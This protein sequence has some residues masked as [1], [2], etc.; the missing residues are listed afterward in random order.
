MTDL[1]IR[2]LESVNARHKFDPMVAEASSPTKTIKA[3]RK[4]KPWYIP[5]ATRLSVRS[6]YVIHGRPP[7][8]IAQA[9]DLTPSQVN[10]LINREGWRR[11]KVSK[12][13]E[14]AAIAD[15]QQNARAD[16]DISRVVETT[17]VLSEELSIRTLNLSSEL[18]DAK[19]PK[20]L[21]MASGAALN[22]TKIARMSRGL[23]TRQAQ[24]ERG[25]VNVNLYVVRGETVQ[26]SE[27]R[28][29]TAIEISAVA[30]TK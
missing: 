12:R 6:L 8:A 28:V 19:D 27:K 20:G 13:I 3:G 7:S 1:R 5:E 11:L 17:A 29:E 21:Q 26:R 30:N 9:L 18:L 14:K 4:L 2:S 25:S 10:G 23:D 22:F 24:D 15:A 16:A